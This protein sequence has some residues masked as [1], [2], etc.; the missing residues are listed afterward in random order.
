LSGGS[1]L[2]NAEKTF[3]YGI[4]FL[5][6]PLADI[7]YGFIIASVVAPRIDKYKGC[8]SI[9]DMIG[10][11]YGKT[12]KI[13]TGVAGT[14][15]SITS[16]GAQASAIGYVFHY[17]LGLEHLTGILIGVG[18]IIIYST[19]GGIKAVTITDVLQFIVLMIAI[20]LICNMGLSKVGGYSPLIEALPD[21]HISLAAVSKQDLVRN[22]EI[23]LIFVLTFIGPSTVPRLL[24]A[25]N[26]SQ[27]VQASYYAA[28][29]YIVF[30][31]L[32]T[33]IGL[34]AKVLKPDL[35]PVLA[36]PYI[37]DL[38]PI[39]FRGV[40]V[41]GLIAIIMSTADSV[42]NTAS[43]L[44]VN[45]IIAPLSKK[46]LSEEA[47]L[48]IARCSTILIG[49]FSIV[50]A[51]SL[52]SV[53]DIMVLSYAF[54]APIV[55]IPFFFALLG[56]RVDKRSF[57]I[58]TCGSCLTVIVWKVLKLEKE[59]FI[60]DTLPATFADFLFFFGSH[61][62]YKLLKPERFEPIP[63]LSMNEPIGDK[64]NLGLVT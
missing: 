27:A 62:Y 59:F 49:I 24:M 8:I 46:D 28:L 7:F 39:G 34:S 51:V 5:I 61:Y 2:G 48:R 4:L 60:R 11:S 36:M 1:S 33:I 18:I 47:K 26:A 16:L 23:F 25:K 55:V 35:D 13:I 6:I 9:G 44:I 58:A 40:A 50:S 20:P 32:V 63:D 30:Y 54:W 17:F 56:F 52:K 38:L 64:K 22:I 37:V 41:A 21:T 15:K 57:L 10:K 43:V 14:L 31:S 45:D 3:K 42:M 29:I 12:P 53:L 19:A